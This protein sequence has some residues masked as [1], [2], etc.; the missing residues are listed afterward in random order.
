MF[1]YKI[2][3]NY[4]IFEKEI[5]IKINEENQIYMFFAFYFELWN[6]IENDIDK[7]LPI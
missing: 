1:V 6:M 3:W 2:F 7:K 5:K 4:K